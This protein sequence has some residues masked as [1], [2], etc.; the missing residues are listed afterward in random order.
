[1]PK[2]YRNGSAMLPSEWLKSAGCESHIRQATVVVVAHL[3]KDVVPLLTDRGMSQYAAETVAKEARM[4]RPPYSRD[5]KLAVGALVIDPEQ[6]GVFAWH[7]GVKDDPLIRVELDGRL[8]PVGHFRVER[9]ADGRGLYV[10][11]I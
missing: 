5:V 2:I 1:M 4:T 11:R 3:K 8:T 9:G 7:Q 6:P 10:E